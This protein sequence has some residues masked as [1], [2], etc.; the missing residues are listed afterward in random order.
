MKLKDVLGEI[1]S[2]RANLVHGRLLEWALTPSLWHA[3]AV[4]GRPHHQAR[5]R[6]GSASRA[7]HRKQAAADPISPGEGG[8]RSRV[9]RAGHQDLKDRGTAPPQP[10]PAVHLA[11]AGEEGTSR[12]GRRGGI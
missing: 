9:L 6:E 1:E 2:D 4:G 5:S 10:R 7:D 8:D 12:S 3:E 11:S